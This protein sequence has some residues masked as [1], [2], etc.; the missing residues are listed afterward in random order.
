MARVEKWDLRLDE[1]VIQSQS[2][3]FRYGGGEG[4]QDCALFAADCVLAMTGV[5]YAS[6]LR[7]YKSKI[8]AY[9]IVSTYGSLEAM[10]TALLGKTPIHPAFAHRGDVMLGSP[11]LAPGEE[12]DE[13]G[14]CLGIHV[15]YP[16]VPSGLRL[17]PRT[18]A[19]LAW[20]IE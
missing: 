13:I 11:E 10:V 3:Q 5:D 9:R 7:G 2:R 1:I 17:L 4:F 20:R 12:G 19:R 18:T 16:Q 14:I 15:A 8:D 6:E